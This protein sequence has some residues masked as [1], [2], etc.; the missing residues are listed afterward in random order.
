[1]SALRALFVGGREFNEAPCV[2]PVV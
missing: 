1:V 2:V